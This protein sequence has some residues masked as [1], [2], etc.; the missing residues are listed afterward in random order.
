MAAI[1]RR[2]NRTPPQINKK[3]IRPGSKLSRKLGTE[4]C[5]RVA[6]GAPKSF[7]ARA[8]GV[9]LNTLLEWE[10]RGRGED[11]RPPTE[12]TIWFAAE[13]EKATG[14]F[15]QTH[16]EYIAGDDDWHARAW[17]LERRFPEEFG[18]REIQRYEGVIDH[19]VRVELAFDATPD[20]IGDGYARQAGKPVR[21]IHEVAL[22]PALDLT[23]DVV[24][25]D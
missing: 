2:H 15:V 21:Q 6:K 18:R 23:D 17:I 24:E 19:T 20:P 8:S 4:I 12:L 25:D 13:M 22:D 11:D 16:V 3:G 9:S 5:D 14:N 10:R 1:E 7:A